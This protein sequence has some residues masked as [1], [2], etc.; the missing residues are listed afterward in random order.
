LIGFAFSAALAFLVVLCVAG[1]GGPHTDNL[2]DAFGWRALQVFSAAVA[3]AGFVPLLTYGIHHTSRTLV[4][5]GVLAGLLGGALLV[6]TWDYS[7]ET[8]SP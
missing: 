6:A 4:V 5:F 8:A 7:E 2:A 1:C 3:I